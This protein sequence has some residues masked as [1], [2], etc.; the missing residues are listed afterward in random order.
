MVIS[1]K[2]LDSPKGYPLVG[3]LIQ[4]SNDPLKFLSDCSQKY[5]DIIP[6]KRAHKPGFI[7]NHPKYVEII[8]KN[9]QIFIKSR[10]YHVIKS[11][12]GEG[13]ITSEGE[14]WYQQRHL[15]QPIFQHQHIPK[16]AD[17]M[18]RSAQKLIATWN[19]GEKRNI[20]D[21][22]MH[23]ALEIVMKCI[24]SEDLSK[25]DSHAISQS[26]NIAHKWFE[27]KQLSDFLFI[28]GLGPKDSQY[29]RQVQKMDAIIYRIIREHRSRGCSDRWDLLSKMLQTW[30][31]ENSNQMSDQQLRDEIAT[32]MLAGHETTAATLSWTWMLL[33]KNPEKL[34]KLEQELDTVLGRKPPTF[35][36]ISKLNYTSWVIKESMRLYPPVSII[37]RICKT[38]STI[39]NYLIP[40]DHFILLSPWVMQR[41]HRF[42]EKPD[43]FTPERWKNDFEKTLL[44]GVY[45]PFGDG[46]RV[47]I[48]KSFAIMEAILV[49]AT[50]GQN[51]RLDLVKNQ[52]IIPKQS[53]TLRPKEGIQV[54][55]TKRD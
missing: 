49:L 40:K 41:S 11:F 18:V 5:G 13:L 32:L 53:F 6:L 37:G 48:G 34:Q 8:L 47:C 26:L 25:Q 39:D 52:K 15:V 50:I 20:H 14:S 22:M 33:S 9:P 3:H 10:A 21:D 35:E 28:P 16:Y 46:P 29:Q 44:K 51:F 27:Y 43:E 17:V 31:E 54:V 38:D 19:S 42:F 23:I 55:I 24:F 4:L 2:S 7:I 12:L 45:F 1:A 30:G 36:D